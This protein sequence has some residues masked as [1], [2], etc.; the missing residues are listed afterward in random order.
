MIYKEH[1]SFLFAS[2][3]QIQ[4]H[5]HIK[6][7]NLKVILPWW[8]LQ[9]SHFLCF[10][11]SSVVIR[12]LSYDHYCLQ[13]R[14]HVYH[15]HIETRV[16]IY[17]VVHIIFC[18]HWAL[19]LEFVHGGSGG[20]EWKSMVRKYAIKIANYEIQFGLSKDL[21]SILWSI[22]FHD[23]AVSVCFIACFD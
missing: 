2:K 6:S 11:I 1:A 16:A 9:C 21:R 14:W 7:F 23:H 18:K 8:N 12:Y 13:V 4:F 17:L 15:T 3:T 5:L 20:I 22:C 10:R 19:S